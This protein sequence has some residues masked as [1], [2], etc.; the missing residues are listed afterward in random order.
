MLLFDIS[1]LMFMEL[2]NMLLFNISILMFMSLLIC[3]FFLFFFFYLGFTALSRIFHL[4]RYVT[5]QHISS[6]V[7]G[8]D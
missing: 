8:A 4:H 5:V 6:D 1:G 3:F 7:Y 2:I